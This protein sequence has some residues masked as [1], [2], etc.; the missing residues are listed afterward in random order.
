MNTFSIAQERDKEAA[1]APNAVNISARISQE[2][3][4]FISQLKIEGAKTPSD[5]L[6]AIIADARRHHRG[7]Q[8]YLSCFHMMR[9]MFAPIVEK[10]RQLE[11]E[12]DRHSELVNHS[13]GWLPDTVAFMVAFGQAG[14][15]PE[16]L[17]KFENGIADRIFGLMQSVL[18]MGI[19]RHCNCYDSATVM[20]RMQPVIHITK[21][22][23]QHAE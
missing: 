15:D 9:E 21:L 3:A 16:L 2:D 7:S 19:T 8:D 17:Q 5:K 12:H 11:H 22:I 4:E 13:L 6:R 1:M 20:R 18:Q 23:Q 10:V 14:D